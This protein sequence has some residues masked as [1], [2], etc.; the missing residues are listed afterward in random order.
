MVYLILVNITLTVCYILYRVILKQFTFFQMNR[1]YLLGA[2]V[3]SLIIPIGLFIDIS[4]HGF[5]EEQLPTVDLSSLMAEEFTVGFHAQQSATIAE[6]LQVLY[7]GGVVIAIGWLCFRF[8]RVM[9]IVRKNQNH[10]SFAFFH[11]VVLEENVRDNQ[12]IVAHEQVHVEQGHSYDVLFMELVKAFNWFN[13]VLY[14][15]LKEIKFQHECIADELCSTD[16]V[17]YAE[18]L[19][20]QAMQVKSVHFLHAFSNKSILKNRITMLFKDKSKKRSKLLYFSIAPVML[21]AILSTLI[22]NTSKAKDIVQHLEAKVEYTTLDN[23]QKQLSLNMLTEEPE[24]DAKTVSAPTVRDTT[25]VE[26]RDTTK[27]FTETEV[28]PEPVGGFANF[29]AW[30]AKNYVYPT[31]AVSA[32][33]EGK[34]TVSFVVE[35]NGAL[36]NFR[37]IDDLGYGTGQAAIDVLKKAKKWKP[38]IQNGRPVRTA[39]TLPISLNASP[40]T[41]KITLKGESLAAS[42]E[43]DDVAN[44]KVFTAV[45]VNPEPVGGMS[46][47]RKW[48]GDNYLYPQGAIDAGV[49]GQVVVSFI[50]ESDGALTNLKVVKDLGYNT[51]EAALAVLRKSDNWRPGIQNGRKVRVGYT[52][53]ITINLEQKS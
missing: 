44:N 2:V 9:R 51:G 41:A 39:F 30:L 50:V 42:S 31:E 38:G 46:N 1:F 21:L 35:N 4:D 32:K 24:E 52:L 48:L 20:A 27:L 17:A 33:V 12:V 36:T 40:V 18:L 5:M 6:I 37:V 7:W 14:S 43:D 49:K 8:F 19:V 28:L 11:R 29:R 25:A 23:M 10:F 15:Y 16:K 53:P 13:P 22:F 34:V 47:F 3:V 26:A 45:E